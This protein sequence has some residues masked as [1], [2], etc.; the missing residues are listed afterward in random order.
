MHEQPFSNISHVGETLLLT[1]GTGAPSHFG[2]QPRMQSHGHLQIIKSE[3]SPQA[4]KATLESSLTLTVVANSLLRVSFYNLVCDSAVNLDSP[5]TS[6]S[7][8]I[9]KWTVVFRL[10]RTVTVAPRPGSH[11]EYPKPIHR[12]LEGLHFEV[13]PI[14]KHGPP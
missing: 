5:R 14:H 11:L 12:R 9:R 13:F 8:S 7:E 10:S 2:I 6:E 3:D 1:Q 4:S